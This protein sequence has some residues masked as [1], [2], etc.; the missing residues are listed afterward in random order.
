MSVL[1]RVSATAV[2]IV[3][4]F[5]LAPLAAAELAA[6]PCSEQVAPT[7]D[8]QSRGIGLTAPKLAALYGP[9]ERRDGVTVYDFHGFDLIEDGCDL[10]LELSLRPP[11]GE[12]L[13]V[14]ALAESLLPNDAEYVGALTLGVMTGSDQDASLWQSPSLAVRFARLGEHRGDEILILYTDGQ[15]SDALGPAARVKL[16][17]VLMPE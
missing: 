10:V 16:W 13:H 2:L 9:G 11:G 6:G 1:V 4:L 14:F 17:T 12:Q 5:G 8:F 15:S 3:T 7:D